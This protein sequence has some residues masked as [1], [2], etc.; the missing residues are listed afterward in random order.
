MFTFQTADF[1]DQFIPDIDIYL[2]KVAYTIFIQEFSQI[3]ALEDISEAEIL[4][5][6][7]LRK[8]KN[9]SFDSPEFKYHHA[10]IVNVPFHY[11]KKTIYCHPEHY[12]DICSYISKLASILYYEIAEESKQLADKIIAE[13]LPSKTDVDITEKSYGNT[14]GEYQKSLLQPI[15]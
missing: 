9:I 14:I 12:N 2:D 13:V 11:F 8:A 6:A 1:L 5:K 7:L 4:L 10:F 3:L 15:D